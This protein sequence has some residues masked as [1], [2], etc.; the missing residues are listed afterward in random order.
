M[1]YMAET[2]P[3]ST[4]QLL[5]VAG[6]NQDIV[7][8]FEWMSTWAHNQR[9]KA[10]GAAQIAG[11]S[12]PLPRGGPSKFDWCQADWHQLA[13]DFPAFNA[14]TMSDYNGL[15]IVHPMQ[16]D[17]INTCVVF[18]NPAL[19]SHTHTRLANKEYLKLCGESRVQ[20]VV[21]N[22]CCIHSFPT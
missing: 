8:D 13:R 3:C 9:R 14:A 19:A 10:R 2:T 5:S 22:C 11:N 18:V 16:L 7:P 1:K 4:H 20:V 12:A 15:A 17:P 6:D 21:F